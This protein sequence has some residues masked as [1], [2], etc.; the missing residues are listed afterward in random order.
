M[1][2]EGVE[3]VQQTRGW[4][5]DKGETVLQRTKENAADYRYFPEPDI[6]PFHPANMAEHLSLP[7][8]PQARRA[9]FHDE[10]GF[11]YADAKILTDDK[12]WADFTE[13]T[14]SEI[15]DWL[16]S[17][18]DVKGES[19]DIKEG[20]KQKIARLTGGWLTSKLM[21]MLNERG[22]L[23]QHI[24]F[25]PENFAEL[26]ALIY[27]NR[28]NSTNAQKILTEM[29][30]NQ[31]DT[32]PTHI[33]EEKGY[34]QISDETALGSAVAEVIK[35]NPMQVEQYK[36]GKEAVL[37]FLIGMVMKATE[38]SADPHVVEKLLKEQLSS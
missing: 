34:G 32:D 10:Y 28:V 17:L 4:D 9:R 25:S 24:S 7:E 30:Q 23:I 31:S 5:E 21:G 33:M 26:I 3:W 11:S 16:Y 29:V 38:G 37:K 13:H 14:M 18:P 27:T 36:Q 6:P 15:V 12:N 20:K 35:S 8:L 2:E 22:I 19:D 1:I